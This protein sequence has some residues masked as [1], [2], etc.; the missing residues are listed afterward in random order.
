MKTIGVIAYFLL[1]LA[2]SVPSL[3]ASELPPSAVRV[4]L[5]AP[6]RGPVEIAIPLAG[7]Q[8][9][10]HLR[11]VDSLAVR[12]PPGVRVMQARD[13]DAGTWARMTWYAGAWHGLIFDG[14][15]LWALEPDAGTS[16]L[17]GV[18]TAQIV[19]VD[20]LPV[21]GVD[22]HGDSRARPDV[23]GAG[24]SALIDHLP[25][26][27]L[28]R[29]AA[30]SQRLPITMVA[31]RSFQTRNG[32][33]SEAV[34]IATFNNV[35][36]IYSNQV[37]VGLKLEHIELLASD[38]PLTGADNSALLDQFGAFM[39]SGPGASIPASGNAHLFVD[40]SSGG[41]GIA[42]IGALCDRKFGQGVNEMSTSSTVSALIFA[43]ELGH[44]FG[45]PHDGESGSACAS[46]PLGLMAPTVGSTDR[47]SQC[48]LDQMAPKIALASCL[49][50]ASGVAPID[51]VGNWFSPVRD[52]EGVQISIEGDNATFVLSY[53]TYLAGRQA[54]MIG[55]A[56]PVPQG[57]TR[58]L[59][60][61]LTIT[62]GA[63]FGSAFNPSDV[64]RRAWGTVDITVDANNCNNA[65]LRVT[66]A[67]P[68]FGPAFSV[69]VTRIASR[70][71]CN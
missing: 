40:R 30:V 69:P 17:T 66:P 2:A 23:T 24:A 37:G 31:D 71:N 22:L 58:K 35:D 25:D 1:A 56:R 68:E 62:S 13:D 9:Q 53:Y 55:V 3:A 61:D 63:G 59:V 5:A 42:W 6:A 4:E 51:V 34:L 32:A 16:T 60:F 57:E 64:Q 8:L 47:F 39:V 36:G 12:M 15:V 14:A 20:E 43:H 70:S 50:A 27:D 7:G 33:N 48:S 44:N 29:S 28:I 18:V 19:R 11:D 52:G 41:S 38:G 67:L 65:Q 54:W 10:L 49:V 45:A 21:D 46:A 26:A